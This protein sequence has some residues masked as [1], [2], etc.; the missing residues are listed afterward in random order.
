VEKRA[1]ATSSSSSSRGKKDDVQ[2]NDLGLDAAAIGIDANMT[3]EERRAVYFAHLRAE[4]KRKADEEAQ[5]EAQA[6]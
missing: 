2:F 5:Q 1:A 3:P 6:G 4:K